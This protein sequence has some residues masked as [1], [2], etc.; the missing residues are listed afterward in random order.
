M[1]T[2]APGGA[3]LRVTLVTTSFNFGGLERQ[4]VL[5][6][7]GL[8]ARSC[9]VTI[10]VMGEGIDGPQRGD[11]DPAVAVCPF[12][13]R[14]KH[15]GLAELRMAWLLRTLRPH[16][17]HLHTAGIL[18]GRVARWLRVPVV[19]RHEHGK[20]LWKSPQMLAEER[21]L[22]GCFH[23]RLA[24]SE[25]IRRLRIEREGCPP[26][27]IEVYPNAVAPHRTAPERQQAARAEL[28]L[29]ADRPLLGTV[30]RFV[31]AKAF[32][33]LL[34]A[35]DLLRRQVPVRFLLVGAGPDF[36]AVRA[37]SRELGLDDVV[38][39]AGFRNDTADLLP[40]LDGYVI[41]SI[42]E[43]LPVSLLEAMGAGLPI[44]ATAVGGI[45][46]V[47]EEGVSGF[48]VPPADPPALAGAMERLLGLPPEAR[49]RMGDAGRDLVR[50][51]YSADALTDRTL[52]LYRQLLA[53]GGGCP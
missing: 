33:D 27:R 8:A 2:S 19:I 37:R 3:P 45:P 46:E 11:L 25:D 52:A 6:A 49:R 34:A 36:D 5:L 20:N 23:R 29:T 17:L 38:L 13:A 18:G 12:G 41:S 48:L 26:D 31:E 28:G 50:R 32:P 7:N 43:G 14:W 16:A 15:R 39:F 30:G 40:L 35:L 21:G 10:L 4:V 9:T 1:S 51:R 42:R 22:A 53:E 44:V 47:L 24:V